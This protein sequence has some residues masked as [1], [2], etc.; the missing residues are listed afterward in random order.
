MLI[1]RETSKV[2]ILFNIIIFIKLKIKHL[3]LNTHLQNKTVKDQTEIEFGI[4]TETEEPGCR[5]YGR[6]DT[7]VCAK[8]RRPKV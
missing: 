2:S 3:V 5:K 6:E 7:E 8:I 1:L 4:H